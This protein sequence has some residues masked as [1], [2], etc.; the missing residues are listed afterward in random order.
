MDS[1]CPKCGKENIKDAKFCK[2]CGYSLNQ[3]Q[4]VKNKKY[5]IIIILFL[6]FLIGMGILLVVYTFNSNN[7]NIYNKKGLSFQYNSALEISSEETEYEI[8]ADPNNR[9]IALKTNYKKHENL[10]KNSLNHSDIPHEIIIEVSV[11]K[12]AKDFK[13]PPYN[14]AS[15]EFYVGH[16]VENNSKTEY[17]IYEGNGFINYY[18]TKYYE[19]VPILYKL[20]VMDVEAI[21]NPTV[22]KI[23]ETIN[24]PQE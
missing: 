23:I 9:Y 4:D 3:T 24:F 7:V 20:R 8:E 1:S 15:P 22:L 5:G 17:D 2:E 13:K 10:H 11:P 21:N 19:G 18:F 6:I 12:S 14:S 16:Y